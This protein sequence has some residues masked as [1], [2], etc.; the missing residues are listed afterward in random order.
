M[1]FNVWYA[2]IIVVCAVGLGAMLVLL[3]ESKTTPGP[4]DTTAPTVVSTINANAATGV[5]INTKFAP[6]FSEQMDPLTITPTTF[7]VTGPG[8]TTVAGTISYIGVTAVFTPTSDLAPDTTYTGT[9]TTGAKDLA[10]NALASNYVWSFTT[11]A[12]PSAS[13]TTAP[14]VVSTINANAATGVAI[15]TKFAPIFSEPMDPLTITPTTFTVTGSGGTTVAGTISYIGVTA[16]FTPTS[17]LAPNTAYTATI[18]TGVKDLAGN[19]LASNYVWSFTTGSGPDNTAPIVSSTVPFNSATSAAINIKI[20]STFSEPMDP[21]TITPTTFTVTGSGGTTV[22]GTIVYTGVT[23]VFTPTSDFALGTTYTATIT[24][25]VKDLAGNAMASNRVWSFTFRTA[26]TSASDTTAPTVSS[27]VPFDN[28]TGVATNANIATIFSEEMDPLTTTTETFT[29]MQGSTPVS[30]AVS[31]VGRTATFDPT[32]DLAFNTTYTATITTGAKDLAGNALASN[33]VWSFTTGS[34]P[35]TT[36]PTVFSTSPDN[37]ATGVLISANI[38][39]TFSE[40]M[41]PLPT[42]EAFTLM[43]GSTPVSGAV[44]YAGTTVT[45]DPENYLVPGTT[46]TATITTGAKDLAHNPLAN[47]YV[48][49][50]TTAA[51]LPA[52]PTAPNLGEAGRFVILASQKITTTVGSVLSNGDVVIMDQARTYYEGFTPGADPGQFDELTNG[53]SY[54]HDDDTGEPLLPVPPPY[55]S[56]IAFINQTRTDVN[57]A[58]TYL[59]AQTLPAPAA[60]PGSDPTELGGKTLYRGIYV[61]A[62]PVKIEQGNLT[63]DA[64]GDENS[65][66]IFQLGSDFT[67]GAPG[68]N[69]ILA[70]SAQAKNVYFQVAGRTIIGSVADTHFYGNVLSWA[71]I[72]VSSGV[73]ITGRL[74]SLTEQVTLISDVVTKAP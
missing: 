42:I 8:G 40:V 65:V 73:N 16:V 24:T 21:L 37:V 52:N 36:A 19:A 27:T 47:N 31:Y 46:Y 13:D 28:A 23:A 72:N 54:A 45:F 29:L 55:A 43:Q 48:W 14:T 5:A 26:A 60:I 63:L 7:T 67:T 9:I 25:G 10:G 15:N 44:S 6:T 50:F 33:R 18:T 59:A 68:G 74:F 56:I 17:N 69:I 12:A 35:D 64:Q 53:L 3:P 38:S 66:W 34:A 4:S 22:A 2:G 49:S 51:V 39:A 32:S 11:A 71:Q 70:N 61:S 1:R 62:V 41:D 58:Y 57:N 30:G 20:S